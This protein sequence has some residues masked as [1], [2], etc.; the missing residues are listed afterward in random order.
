MV[1][2]TNDLGSKAYDRIA[3]IPSTISIGS[4][5]DFIDY[6]RIDLQNFMNDTISTSDVPTK[7]QNILISIGCMF[8]LARMIG[9]NADFDTTLGEFM[10][11]K[12]DRILPEARELEFYQEHIN[13]NLKF[14][15]AGT[16]HFKK[17]YG[18]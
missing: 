6:G 7:Y 8:T 2:T 4:I 9:A 11:R 3:N 10:L 16:H 13:N 12:V 17:V 14:L 5:V 18:V 1:I 15:K